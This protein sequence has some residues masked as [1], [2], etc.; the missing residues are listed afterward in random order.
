MPGQYFSLHYEQKSDTLILVDLPSI[1][2]GHP[3]LM[4]SYIGARVPHNPIALGVESS[5]SLD[6]V[7]FDPD[8]AKEK[9]IVKYQLSVIFT[10]DTEAVVTANFASPIIDGIPPTL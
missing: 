4:A 1:E 8:I 10:S 6:T 2:R 7:E 3:T 9:D 5:F